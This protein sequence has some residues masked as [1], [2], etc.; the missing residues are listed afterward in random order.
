MVISPDIFKDD[1]GEANSF[2]LVYFGQF[3][4]CAGMFFTGGKSNLTQSFRKSRHSADRNLTRTLNCVLR[5]KKRY[6]I[7]P[8]LIQKIFILFLSET[9]LNF[10]ELKRNARAL[11]GKSFF[12]LPGESL[13]LQINIG[14]LQNNFALK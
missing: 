7:Q 14:V 4:I 2:S 6:S 10:M 1:N 12:S 9:F 11:P 8:T 13:V 5:N 3:L